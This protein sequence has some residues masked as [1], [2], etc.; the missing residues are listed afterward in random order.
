MSK[1]KESQIEEVKD[2]IEVV[3]PKEPVALTEDEE[4]V[5]QKEINF[6]WSRTIY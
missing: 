5:D 2:A 4:R 3:A 6:N 1:L